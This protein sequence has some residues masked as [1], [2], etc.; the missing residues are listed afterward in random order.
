MSDSK[1]MIKVVAGVLEL[2]GAILVQERPAGKKRAF[3]WE[4]PG[5]KIE[6]GEKEEVCV[7]REFC[8]ELGLHV[9]VGEKLWSQEH[10][11]ED[12]IVDI[13]FFALTHLSELAEIKAYDGQVVAWV[14]KTELTSL[15]FCP[16]DRE[17]IN[18]LMQA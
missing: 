18:F 15:D 4:F 11:Y 7:Q 9:R 8:E 2:D 1:P 14:Q 10:A 5:G 6:H 17:F 16:A 12:I 3:L 13:S